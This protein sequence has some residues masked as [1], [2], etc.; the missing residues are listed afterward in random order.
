MTSSDIDTIVGQ[1][2]LPI[3]ITNSVGV[4][5][6]KL[7]LRF[8]YALTALW[9]KSRTVVSN[10]QYA[11]HQFDVPLL[12]SENVYQRDIHGNYDVILDGSNNPVLT[13]L[14]TAGDPVLDTNGDPVLKYVAGGI[15][16]DNNGD[17]VLLEPRKLM[18]EFDTMLVDG[19]YYFATASSSLS[20]RDTI[21]MT[22]V[23][24]LRDDIIPISNRLLEQTELFFQP[25]TTVGSI[26]VVAEGAVDMRISAEQQLTV[27]LLVSAQ[28]YEAPAVRSAMAKSIVT[29]ISSLLAAPTVSL[30]TI[31]STLD[32]MLG[33]EVFGIV[34][35]GLGGDRLLS[36]ITLKD[37]SQRLVI[38]KRLVVDPSNELIVE[39]DINVNF[40]PHL[41]L[42]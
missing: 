16:Y 17:P 4:V 40:T 22:I 1:F 26:E 2:L 25:Q 39:N 21:A 23:N 19:K 29:T 5:R 36:T 28:V 12:Y 20:Y 15:V 31:T 27:L 33:D 9:R 7:T 6:E 38:K 34:I 8:G 18:R 13:K 11:R 37:T 24:W 10:A 41:K 42:S 3:N 32:A 14:H 30:K 35:T